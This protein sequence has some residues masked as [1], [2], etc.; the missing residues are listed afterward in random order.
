MFWAKKCKSS[1][2][3]QRLSIA[4]GGWNFFIG[5]RTFDASG[6]P[7]LEA[8]S[9]P[10]SFCDADGYLLWKVSFF[11]FFFRLAAFQLTSHGVDLFCRLWRALRIPLL[12]F[13]SGSSS[14]SFQARSHAGDILHSTFSLRT[15]SG[16]CRS[17]SASPFFNTFSFEPACKTFLQHCVAVE[18]YIFLTCHCQ[19]LDGI[20][21]IASP[22]HE[23]TCR[24]AA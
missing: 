24:F 1:V 5:L 12:F 23:I 2:R 16:I 11:Y 4:R 19:I 7:C 9:S 14:H 13:S 20:V 3:I 6:S 17:L 8:R 18:S 10:R 22:S 15:A 21:L